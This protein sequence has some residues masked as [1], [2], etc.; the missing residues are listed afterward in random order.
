MEQ[1]WDVDRSTLE[2]GPGKEEAASQ[3]LRAGIAIN[4]VQSTE[5]HAADHDG[6]PG[7]R[8]S[9]EWNADR[10]AVDGFFEDGREDAHAEKDRDRRVRRN[11]V[12]GRLPPHQEPH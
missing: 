4:D 11:R 9:G 3:V 8:E 10:K 1:E 6:H 2:I 7:P 12:D 5:N